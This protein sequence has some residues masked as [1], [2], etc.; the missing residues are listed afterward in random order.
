MKKILLLIA[1]LFAVNSFSQEIKYKEYSYSE[2]FKLI[3]EEKDTIFKLSD[4]IVKY[5]KETDS[6]HAAKFNGNSNY[7]D[8]IGVEL[9]RKEMILINKEIYL[10][11]V[12]FLTYNYKIDS[13][14]IRTELLTAGL[15]NITFNKPVTFE[16]TIALHIQNCNFKDTFYINNSE[17]TQQIHNYFD[18]NIN[19]NRLSYQD[20]MVINSKFNARAW[21]IYINNY[22]NDI[23]KSGIFVNQNKFKNNYTSINIHN[24]WFIEIRENE[25][26]GNIRTKIISINNKSLTL[27]N[28][29]FK[30][31]AHFGI[32]SE[33]NSETIKIT[34]NT[35]DK[36]VEIDNFDFVKETDIGWQQWNNKLILRS[37]L[38]RYKDE[39]ALHNPQLMDS[40]NKLNISSFDA[41]TRDYSLIT[42]YITEEQTS[43]KKSF[44][45]EIK[46][47]FKHYNLYKENY[48][49]ENANLVYEDIKDLETKRFEN[50]YDTNPSFKTFF[51]WRINQFLKVFSGYGKEPERAVVFSFYVILSFAFIYLLFPNSWDSHG[52]KRLMHRFEF[53]QKYLRRKEGMHTLYLEGKQ[54]EISSYEDF[55]TNLEQAH[56]ELPSF[57]ITWSKPLYNASM[58]SSRITSRFLKMT[59][60]LQG[61]WQDLSPK[62]KRWKNFQIGLLLTVGLFYDLFIKVLNALMLSINTFTTL[63][64]GEIPIKGLPRYLA[65]IQGFIGWFMLTIFSVSLISQ[66][67]N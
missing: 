52:K 61:K 55:K 20:I 13:S 29:Y 27:E 47:R 19:E 18:E 32:R 53:F 57:F 67:L 63:G 34:E 15:Y 33:K 48:D 56:L 12:Q 7:I 9:N 66:L 40:L 42:Q 58:F 26:Y 49:L 60:V 28:N 2:F 37:G 51:K 17:T 36:V 44:S 31:W 64:F 4:A 41:F 25:F 30:Q 10:K 50:L 22:K 35:F 21:L 24:N 39:Y 5:N 23:L 43:N 11:N 46:F 62:Q 14:R 54:Q 16:K 8:S 6:I 59:D 1:V 3:E 45:E 38:D 65:I